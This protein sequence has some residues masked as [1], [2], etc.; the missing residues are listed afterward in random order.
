MPCRCRLEIPPNPDD[1]ASANRH[2][3]IATPRPNTA[4]IVERTCIG[5]AMIRRLVL[6]FY[7]EARRD[8]SIGPIFDS[9]VGSWDLRMERMCSFWS[10]PLS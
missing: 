9:R 6:V 4:D 2:E 5:E 10:R 1:Q 7:A 3:R 8:G